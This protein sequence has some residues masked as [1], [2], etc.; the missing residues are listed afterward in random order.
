MF[1]A[2]PQGPNANSAWKPFSP[3]HQNLCFFAA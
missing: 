3:S 1:H 2:K